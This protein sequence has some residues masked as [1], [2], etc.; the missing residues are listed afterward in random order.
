MDALSYIPAAPPAI[1]ARGLNGILMRR[2]HA[3]VAAP[4]TLAMPPTTAAHPGVP[5]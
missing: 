2:L 1:A 4:P 3:A 5:L